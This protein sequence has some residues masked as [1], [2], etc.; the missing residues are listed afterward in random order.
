M[1]QTNYTGGGGAA[2]HECASDERQLKSLYLT[3]YHFTATQSIEGLGM[4]TCD[5]DTLPR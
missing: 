2:K 1:L 5:K 4:E 3:E